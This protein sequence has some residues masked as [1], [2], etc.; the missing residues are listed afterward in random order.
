MSMPAST[1]RPRVLE[2]SDLRQFPQASPD[3]LLGFARA[4]PTK[5]TLARP[6]AVV[7]A[8]SQARG[9]SAKKGRPPDCIVS[10]EHPRAD[11]MFPENGARAEEYP[12]RD[13]AV[14]AARAGKPQGGN[15]GLRGI[16][17]RERAV[18]SRR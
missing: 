14:A 3:P 4:P 15:K 18:A 11:K 10:A 5:R 13:H 2:S 9:A 7:H 12:R 16:A 17:S 1:Q 6:S 8:H